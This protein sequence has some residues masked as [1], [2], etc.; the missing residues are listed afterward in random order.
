MPNVQPFAKMLVR[1][2]HVYMKKKTE[3]NSTWGYL[4]ISENK[5]G[6]GRLNI[7]NEFTSFYSFTKSGE[8]GPSQYSLPSGLLHNIYKY[9]RN[10]P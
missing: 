5:M 8:L 1:V 2:N 3:L 9:C 4:F 7:W 10:L 6:S